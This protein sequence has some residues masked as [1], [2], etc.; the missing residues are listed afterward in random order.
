ME[1]HDATFIAAATRTDGLPPPM[2]AEIAFAGR[3][4][5]G[6]SSLINSMARRNKLVR[7][8]STPGLT[9]QIQIFR[10]K[11]RDAELD[12]VD[13]PG[14]GYAARSKTERASWGP[15]IEGF[16]RE[17]AGLRGV[18]VLVDARRGLEDDDRQLLD[19][20]DS[21][22][23]PS[24]VV[25]TKVDKLGSNDRRKQLEAL[26]RDAGRQIIGYSVTANLGRDE[27]WK[28]VLDA[29]S[30]VVSTKPAGR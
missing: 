9:R 22:Q 11:L 2:F 18:L 14:Y 29:C 8:G 3:S 20:L 15:M 30:I 10:M 1:V 12:F 16:L 5:V 28:V 6:K 25:A 17:R 4:N 27:L 24:F 7:T 21:I 13:L 26:K 23:I 19:F